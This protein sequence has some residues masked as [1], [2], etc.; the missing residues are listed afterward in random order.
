[1]WYVW[2]LYTKW[3]RKVSEDRWHLRLERW[4]GIISL[5]TTLEKI[6]L[7]LSWFFVFQIINKWKWKCIHFLIN[8]WWI[9]LTYNSTSRTLLQLNFFWLFPD[10]FFSY[11]HVLSK[12]ILLNLLSFATFLSLCLPQFNSVWQMFCS[13]TTQ[14]FQ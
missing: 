4:E 11:C 12:I 8:P 10:V 13:W 14:W 6:I 7:I 2:L 5:S 9:S 1:M 3:T